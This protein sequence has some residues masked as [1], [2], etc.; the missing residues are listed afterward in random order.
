MNDAIAKQALKHWQIPY[1]S[2]RFIAQRENTVYRVDDSTTGQVWAL[3]LHRPG[4]RTE[5]ELISE[6]Q[7]L[8]YL[9]SGGLG[10]PLPI[11]TRNAEWCVEH[12]G[13]WVD[14]QTWLPGKSINPDASEVHYQALGFT[15]AKLHTLSDNWA[16]PTHF[17]R[18][19]WD[20][21]GF[22]GDTPEWGCFWENPALDHSQKK[23]F[24]QFRHTASK[25]LKQKHNDLDF[26]LIHADLVSENVL[27]NGSNIQL[28][29][30]DD[31]GFGYRLFE[32]ATVILRLQRSHG[33]ESRTQALIAGY[34]SVRPLS[35]DSLDMFIAL[36]ACTYIGWII[37]RRNEPNGDERCERF[38]KT[39]CLHVERWLDTV[40][41]SAAN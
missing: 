8:Q 25:V 16:K 38:I 37:P 18:P 20:L 21:N 33:W 35:L 41:I 12:N 36:R 32:L 7:W 30:F 28:I 2:I 26:G 13:H 17:Q 14:M 15:M 9:S 5:A 19:N 40:D 34:Q 6:C 29:D 23:L 3:R 10:V 27:V 31:S 39:G 22:L 4:L 1:T 11:A 24:E